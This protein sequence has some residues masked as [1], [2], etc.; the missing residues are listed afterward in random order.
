MVY[1]EVLWIDK[2]P[3]MQFIYFPLTWK[4]LN[5]ESIFAPVAS[6]IMPHMKKML[7]NYWQIYKINIGRYERLV[8]ALYSLEMSPNPL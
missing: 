3:Q 1:V 6:S 8:V 5:T 7:L 2:M 4:F